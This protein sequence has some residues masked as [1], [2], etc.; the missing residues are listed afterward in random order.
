[1][2]VNKV[3]ALAVPVRSRAPIAV[4]VAQVTAILKA[5]VA[6]SVAKLFKDFVSKF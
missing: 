1:M 2:H 6:A 5:A 3:I 4:V